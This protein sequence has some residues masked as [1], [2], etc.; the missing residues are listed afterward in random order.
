MTAAATNKRSPPKVQ[1]RTLLW[2]PLHFVSFGAG[3]GLSPVAPGTMGTFATVP[4]VYLCAQLG[5]TVYITLTLLV[6]LVGIWS[7]ARTAEALG[8]HDHGSI[9]IDEIAGFF[10]TMTLL[11]PTW[12]TLAL[13][14]AAF[15][16]LDIAKPWPISVLDRRMH[17]G[18][19]IMLDDI[20]AGILACAAVHVILWLLGY[21][22]LSAVLANP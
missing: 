12:L 13:G 4:L 1:P 16:L 9:V 11:E 7:A 21:T 19:G 10:L 2:H 5:I 15:R 18:L 8:V 22:A 6:C 3:S 14:F 20:L 17:G